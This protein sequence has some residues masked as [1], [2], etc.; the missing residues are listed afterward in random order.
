MFTTKAT[1]EEVSRWSKKRVDNSVFSHQLPSDQ[2][3]DQYC[4]NCYWYESLDDKY[5]EFVYI[6]VV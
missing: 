5:N 2:Y 1:P 6:E 3:S 4:D